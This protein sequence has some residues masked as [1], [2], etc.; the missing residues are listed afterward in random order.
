MSMSA[1][2]RQSTW[3][4]D[5]PGASGAR[6]LGI[7]LIGGL[8]HCFYRRAARG[9]P[10]GRAPA[11]RAISSARRNSASPRRPQLPQRRVQIAAGSDREMN[12]GV[13]GEAAPNA[14]SSRVA[15][16]SCAA[17]VAASLI[18]SG[19]PLAAWNRSL[20]VGIGRDQAGIDR[21]PIGANQALRD[22]ALHHALEK[23]A[24]HGRSG[25]NARV[26]SSRTSSDR[27]PYHPVR[28]RRTSDSP[29]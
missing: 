10:R 19:L 2:T 3:S 24:Q 13:T 12:F 15:R 28:A 14:A 21:K 1:R 23:A 5:A 8:P 7:C 17:R 22:T 25:E 18:S 29:D 16:Y 11:A 26:C 9:L 4:I 20:L 27:E 6:N